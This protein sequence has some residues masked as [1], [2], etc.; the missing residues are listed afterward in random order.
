[1]QGRQPLGLLPQ[2]LRGGDYHHHVGRAVGMEVLVGYVVHILR[3]GERCRRKAWGLPRCVAVERDV[4]EP[5]G[6]AGGLGDAHLVYRA[7]VPQGEPGIP[8]A[9]DIVSARS[10]HA[11]RAYHAVVDADAGHRRAVGREHHLQAAAP[12]LARGSYLIVARHAD[13]EHL[14]VVKIAPALKPSEVIDLVKRVAV[15]ARGVERVCECRAVLHGGRPVA[16]GKKVV[17][18][19]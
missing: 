3:H 13:G 15:V 19:V 4:V 7:D 14:R 12:G 18:V 1:M 17:A 2:L 9:H 10:R 11:D 6:A 16:L 8:L 5:H